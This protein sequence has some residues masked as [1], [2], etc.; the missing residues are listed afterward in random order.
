[1]IARKAITGAR[2]TIVQA[3]LKKGALVPRH[4]HAGE[5]LIYVLRGALRMRVDAADLTIREGDVLQVPPATPHQAEA[6]DDTFLLSV[7]SEESGR[8]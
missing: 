6:I 7:T 4:Q 1:M 3:Y 5:Q 8:A 2:D